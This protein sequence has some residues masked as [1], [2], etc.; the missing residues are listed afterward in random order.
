MRLNALVLVAL[1]GLVNP[2]FATLGPKGQGRPTVAKKP[3]AD[4]K[5]QTLLT[6]IDT[7]AAKL[8]GKNELT[9]PIAWRKQSAKFGLP[10]LDLPRALGGQGLPASQMVKVFEHVGKY[11]LDL[12]DVV[13]G[14]HVRPL[15]QSKQK[16]VRQVAEKVAKGR[17]YVAIAIT[18]KDA[19]SN[20]RAMKSVSEK[21]K[22]G[23]LLTGAKMFNARFETATHVILFARSPVQDSA[24]PKLNAFVVPIDYPGLKFE[25]LSAHGLLGNS[26][27]G[28]SFDHMFVPEKYRIGGEGEGGKAFRDHF[29][30]WRLMQASA[31]IG[32]GK[33]ALDQ[34]VARMRTRQAFGGPIGR[35]THFQQELA[36]HTAKL[37]M[38][39]LLVEQAAEKLDHGDDEGAM[40][41]VAMAKGEGVEWALKAADFSMEL[42]GAEGYSPDLTDLGQR[43]RD[44]QGLRI[45]DGTTH[46]M[47][48][49]VVRHV[50]GAD[51]WDMAIGGGA[52]QATD[53]SE[54]HPADVFARM[55]NA[56]MRHP[57]AVA[58][59]ENYS[60]LVLKDGGGACPTV[61][62]ANLI[63]ALG[64]MSGKAEVIDL[65][66][67]IRAAYK[68]DPLLERGRLSNEQVTRV[69]RFYGKKFLPDVG[70]KIRVDYQR[71][72]QP[73]AQPEGA[74]GWTDLDSDL[75]KV[76]ENELKLVSYTV[77]E[78]NGKVI[79]RHFV[80]LKDRAGDSLFVV[81]P[82]SPMK[83]Y[84]YNLER[85][86][87]AGG[88]ST[89]KLVRPGTP[90]RGAQLF[91]VNSVFTI[92]PEDVGA[93]N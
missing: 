61:A 74:S 58:E 49:E 78:A 67:A 77:T 71:S 35:F 76:R 59:Q 93:R 54:R 27:G 47:R 69:L 66:K 80:V 48:Q 79:G 86:K 11:S 85:E 63:Q 44:L 92:T 32:T 84:A 70:F 16:E 52:A 53:R 51:L 87:V 5:L 15:L 72:L 39:S 37:H 17:A 13:G 20:M 55:R 73:G 90:E 33:G 1:A 65:D 57:N 2:A 19:G 4:P 82:T 50:Y 6:R 62:A 75:L 64:V 24:T 42:H 40:P 34:A 83:D 29:L 12:R 26:F 81:D 68:S 56:K 7:L 25:K 38:A 91:T 3:K 22:G 46:I 31:A 21:T 43:V 45:A 36:E 8:K 88:G 89:L 23:Y 10:G 30:Y 9:S 41:L 28:V 14:A 60:H 18:E